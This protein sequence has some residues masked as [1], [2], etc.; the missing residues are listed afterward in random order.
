MKSYKFRRPGLDRTE[1]ALDRLHELPV[2]LL[3]S[4]VLIAVILI[5]VQAVRGL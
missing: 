1:K 2:I 4:V 3:P 5:I